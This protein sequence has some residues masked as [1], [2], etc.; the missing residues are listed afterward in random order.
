MSDSG[1]NL[2]ASAQLASL[3]PVSGILAVCDSPV[4]LEQIAASPAFQAWPASS[5]LACFSLGE[6]QEPLPPAVRWLVES[7]FRSYVILIR[8]DSV[9]GGYTLSAD[10]LWRQLLDSENVWT[11]AITG[12]SPAPKTDWPVLAPS[13]S[14]ISWLREVI[15]LVQAASPRQTTLFKAG[16]YLLHDFLDESHS[17]SQSMEGG[18]DADLWHAIMHRREPDYG[19]AKYWFRRVGAHPVHDQL[20]AVAGPILTQAGVSGFS[21]AKWD[22]LRFV[23]LCERVAQENSP[24]NRAAREVQW[25]EMNLH[26]AHCARGR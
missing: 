1:L 3:E 8:P 4:S 21:K 12:V 19:N 7:P 13:H 6:R 22:A 23:D 26:L 11:G 18:R 10:A 5:P 20:A 25:L 24:A 2:C 17:Q 14:T 9:A 16:L 15:E